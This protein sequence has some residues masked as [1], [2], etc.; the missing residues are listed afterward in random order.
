MLSKNPEIE[1]P[2]SRK[3]SRGRRSMGCKFRV[4]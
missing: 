4:L 1:L 2:F 3:F